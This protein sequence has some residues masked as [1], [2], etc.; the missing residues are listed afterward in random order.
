MKYRPLFLG[1]I[2]ILLLL[3]TGCKQSA[4]QEESSLNIQVVIPEGIMIPKGMVW[5]PGGTF[6]QGA[7]D[8]DT[9]SLAHEKPAHPVAV[10]GFFMDTTEV[11]N[12]Q[13]AAFVK[14]TGYITLAERSVDWEILKKQL[15]PGTPKP[16]DSLLQPG[17]LVFKKRSD[18]VANLYDFSQWW[19]FKTGANWKH[20][21]GPESSIE[22]KEQHPVVHIA[23]EDAL[24]YCKWAG[25]SLPTEA[26]WE[27]AARA[28]NEAHVF[29]WGARLEQLPELANTWTG[30][31]PER[32]SLL[33]GYEGTAPVG[34]YSPNA[35]NLYDMAGNVWEWTQDWYAANHYSAVASEKIL[36]NPQ[37]ASYPKNQ[38]VIKGGSFL[39]HASYCAS[40][41]ISARMASTPDSSSEHK[42]FRTVVRVKKKK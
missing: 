4:P 30:T 39:C 1:W 13:F 16:H 12:A 34:S 8:A 20:P 41:R 42:G 35:F 40:F 6:M 22:G 2:L 23:Y 28:G 10:D 24:A 11:T 5:I 7:I 17:S 9:L 29:S 15:P 31:F 19:Q 36:V 25:R 26:E 37:G 32:N 33:D 3:E 14:A 38:K 21:Q 18:G 27:Y